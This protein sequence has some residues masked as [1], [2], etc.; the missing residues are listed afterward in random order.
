[1]DRWMDVDNYMDMDNRNDNDDDD[2]IMD[3]MDVT[4]VRLDG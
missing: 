1:M 2:G 3:K 4:D